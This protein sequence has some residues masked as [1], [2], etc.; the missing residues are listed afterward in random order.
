MDEWCDRL[1]INSNEPIENHLAVYI[2]EIDSM[3]CSPLNSVYNFHK[4]KRG[5]VINK[6]QD[7]KLTVN[8]F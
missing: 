5:F 3:I 7:S 4:S 1:K 8:R 2:V 6:G